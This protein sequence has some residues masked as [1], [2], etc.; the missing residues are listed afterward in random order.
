MFVPDHERFELAKDFAS[1]TKEV[2]MHSR[3]FVA[4]LACGIAAS[5]TEAAFKYCTERKQFNKP[6]A[7][8]QLVQA[9]LVRCVSIT[10]S[11]ILLCTHITKMYE[12]MKGTSDPLTIGRIAMAKAE[13]TKQTREVC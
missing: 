8:F 2:L 3:L 1:G 12:S 5:A 6:I 11:L 10:S 7:Q 13:V 9:K 4:W